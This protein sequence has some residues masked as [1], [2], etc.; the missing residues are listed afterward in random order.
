[1]ENGGTVVDRAEMT[2]LGEG[3]AQG[4]IIEAALDRTTA[5]IA[6]MVE[7]ASRHGVRAM[8]RP[9]APPGENGQWR[10]RRGGHPGAYRR[11]YRG[12]LG[13]EE[14][15]MATSPPRP[16]SPRG[17]WSSSTHGEAVPSSPSHGRRGRHALQ[18]RRR[19]GELYRAFRARPCRVRQRCC[20]RSWCT[21]PPISR[22]DGH[23][24]FR[25]RWPMGGAVTN[26]TAVMHR[27][28]PMIRP[29]SRAA[30]STVGA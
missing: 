3:L 21:A 20:A 14:S 29:S 16:V 7:E 18:R 9:S 10:R 11:S 30:S 17:L 15:R 22:I 26:I 12:D 6:T 8:R 24:A 5:A 13:E 28:L 1:M 27:L 25:T 2:R 19:C 4:R 23:Q